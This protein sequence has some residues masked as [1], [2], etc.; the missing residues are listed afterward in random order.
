[1]ESGGLS[2]LY[3]VLPIFGPCNAILG[4]TLIPGEDQTELKK[5]F[6]QAKNKQTQ[7]VGGGGGG[8]GD[9]ERE[10]EREERERRERR[11]REREEREKWTYFAK[12]VAFL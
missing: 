9:R 6:K 11:E 4:S 2:Q 8:G 10:R 12:K 3:L 7:K 5:N 1:M